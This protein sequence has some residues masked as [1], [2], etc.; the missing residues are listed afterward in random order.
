MTEAE[1]AADKKTIEKH[2]GPKCLAAALGYTQQRVQNW[3]TRGIP[4][5]ERV[6]N[7]ILRRAGETF[8]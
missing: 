6:H 3:L 5:Q 7:K 2:G 1:L 8:K 4:F